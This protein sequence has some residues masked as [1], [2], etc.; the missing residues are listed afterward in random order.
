MI[1]CLKGDCHGQK[2]IFFSVYILSWTHTDNKNDLHFFVSLI[3]AIKPVSFLALLK[4]QQILP[5][6]VWFTCDVQKGQEVLT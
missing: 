5:V 2:Q 1:W 6:W 3:L 4:M